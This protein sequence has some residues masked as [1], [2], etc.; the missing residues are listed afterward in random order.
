MDAPAEHSPS[1]I[2]ELLALRPSPPDAVA[3]SLSSSELQ[4]KI[5]QA[6]IGAGKRGIGTEVLADRLS[7]S[8]TT[9]ERVSNLLRYD[10]DLPYNILQR[11]TGHAVVLDNDEYERALKDA[12]ARAD[13]AETVLRALG[14]TALSDMLHLARIDGGSAINAAR[15]RETI[16]LLLANAGLPVYFRHFAARFTD[17]ELLRPDKRDNNFYRRLQYMM[18][19]PLFARIIEFTSGHNQSTYSIYP[20]TLDEAHRSGL[21]TLPPTPPKPSPKPRVPKPPKE[22]HVKQVAPKA[23]SPAV[24]LPKKF[25]P[26]TYEPPVS[27]VSVVNLDISPEEIDTSAALLENLETSSRLELEDAER[28]LLDKIAQQ[29]EKTTGIRLLDEIADG[30]VRMSRTAR[31]VGVIISYKL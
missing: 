5:L 31:R 15:N 18:R 11:R 21:I 3:Q 4:E 24:Q 28:H 26:L 23:S 9:T 29:Y 25:D 14:D 2:D 6:A 19:R 27:R 30:G 8:V 17:L 10:R 7:I 22:K 16:K 1:G 13:K 12:E 20:D